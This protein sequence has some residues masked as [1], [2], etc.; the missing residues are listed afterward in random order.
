[1]QATYTNE[2]AFSILN[3]SNE[4]V[5]GL[6]GKWNKMIYGFDMFEISYTSPA[7]LDHVDKEIKNLEKIWGLKEEW[8]QKYIKD[9]KDIS[10]REIQWEDLEEL[11]DDYIYQLNNLCKEPHIKKWGIVMAFK[12]SID[13]FKNVLPLI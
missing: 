6:R 10:F 7:D 13:N 3:D 4:V 12:A 1:M 5:K 11:A 9:I 8:D 2:T